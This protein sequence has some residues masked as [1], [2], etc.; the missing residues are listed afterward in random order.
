M[1][2]FRSLSLEGQAGPHAKLAP[3][4]RC[5]A[6]GERHDSLDQPCVAPALGVVRVNPALTAWTFRQG[7][8]KSAC[9]RG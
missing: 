1:R 8:K 7:K 2:L 5:A 6:L 3:M 9:K 4:H